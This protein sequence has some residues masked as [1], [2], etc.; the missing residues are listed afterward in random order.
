MPN[1]APLGPPKPGPATRL[2]AA[3]ETSTSI[4]LEWHAPVVG[5]DPVYSVRYRVKGTS[6][7]IVFPVKTSDT[8]LNIVG[9]KPRTTY[10][11]EVLT[12]DGY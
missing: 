3:S 8:K 10:E 6:A 7:W 2:E 11:F 12:A 5:Y 4:L 9:L 1:P